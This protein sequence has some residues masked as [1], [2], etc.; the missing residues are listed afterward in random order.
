MGLGFDEDRCFMMVEIAGDEFYFQTMSRKGEVVDSG[1][2]PRQKQ[3]A[4]LNL[5]AGTYTTQN[6]SF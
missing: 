1:E 3:T 2:F 5:G 6:P 4:Q